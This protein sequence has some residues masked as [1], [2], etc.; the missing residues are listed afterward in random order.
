MAVVMA[1][2]IVTQGVMLNYFGPNGIGI[3]GKILSIINLALWMSFA[4]SFFMTSVRKKFRQFHFSDIINRF[5]MG[6]WIAGTSI[7]GILIHRQFF[8]WAFVVEVL[9]YV[10]F[11]LWLVYL[12]VCMISIRDIYKYDLM[13][14]VNGIILLT[15]V[16]TQSLVLLMNTVYAETPEFINISMIAI[17]VCFYFMAAFLVTKRHIRSRASFSVDED[18]NNTNCILHGALSITGLACLFST[19]VNE[20]IIL[21]IW[22]CAFTVFILVELVEIYRLIIRIRNHGI[23]MGILVYDVSQWSR[24]FTFGMF[25]T[26]SFIL[27]SQF[28]FQQVVQNIIVNSGLWF[29]LV[30]TVME[31]MLSLK[32]SF[33]TWKMNI[34]DKRKLNEYHS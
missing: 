20:Q 15:T 4:T 17:G 8:G 9:L 3:Y 22:I 25:Y 10:N 18:W 33:T 32:F 2:G 6:T 21:C 7:C 16:S 1:I 12:C 27:D 29:I 14:K 26:F 5:G 24:I 30:L 11:V 31:I 28:V 19:N 23:R 34:V 13:E